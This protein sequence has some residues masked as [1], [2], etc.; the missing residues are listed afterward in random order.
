[1][2]RSFE[3]KGGLFTIRRNTESESPFS[4]SVVVG[5]DDAKPWIS[6]TVIRELNDGSLREAADE[7]M[8]EFFEVEA[9]D[10]ARLEIEEGLD[11]QIAAVHLPGEDG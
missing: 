11:R 9:A 5:Q 10:R 1:M 6:R 7:L 8:D 2:A 4:L 3:Y